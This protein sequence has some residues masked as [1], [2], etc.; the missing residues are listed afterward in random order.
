MILPGPELL[1]PLWAMLA[2]RMSDKI[3]QKQMCLGSDEH[4][5]LWPHRTQQQLPKPASHLH[6]LLPG[7]PSLSSLPLLSGG[8]GVVVCFFK[9]PVAS[10]PTYWPPAWGSSRAGA[11]EGIEVGDGVKVTD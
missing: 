8:E 6:S 5:P 11:G 9:L 1:V 7:T 2:D 3:R 10:Y 4:Q